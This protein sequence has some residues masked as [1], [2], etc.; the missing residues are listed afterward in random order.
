LYDEFAQGCDPKIQGIE[1]CRFEVASTFKPMCAKNGTTCKR[2]DRLI[3]NFTLKQMA[4]ADKSATPLALRGTNLS[5]AQ[6]IVYNSPPV[7]G[8]L[9]VEVHLSQ[10]NTGRSIE[11]AV[12]NENPD[13]K[14]IWA[15]CESSD[16][17]VLVQ[18][19]STTTA[20]KMVITLRLSSWASTRA[21]KVRFQIANTGPSPN[22]TKVLEVPVLIDGVCL[23][24][25]GELVEEG[26]TVLAY[27]QFL[28]NAT[29]PC[30]PNGRTCT[31]GALSSKGNF[32][33]CS[34]RIP[35]NCSSPWNEGIPNGQSRVAFATPNV[36]YGMQCQQETRVCADG[37]LSGSA[38]FNS[39]VVAPPINC[40]TPWGADL[41]HGQSVVAYSTP[42]VPYGRDCGSVQQNRMCN[43]GVVTGG[44][45]FSVPVC[46]VQP[47]RK[48]VTP[49]GA[50]VAHGL[51]VD[52]YYLA[53]L[54]FGQSCRAP[55][56]VESR[57][58]NDGTLSG[59]FTQS[60]CSMRGP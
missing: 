14:L 42:S 55:G 25:W 45:E 9:P 49:W 38:Q 2:P 33:T 39:C 43:N 18:C 21:L 6:T 23:T 56:A 52:A 15:L 12:S 53:L 20:G 57:T 34:Q 50:E 13:Q 44:A 5:F 11:V 19:L 37:V 36:P 17:A 8:A 54:N 28:V 51:S 48:C 32:K 40:K 3:V 26:T 24:P 58:C 46:A 41:A 7:V 59:S 27:D 22:V 29:E 10:V 30:T 60:N 47:P 1:H 4:S 35:A 31:A 16:R